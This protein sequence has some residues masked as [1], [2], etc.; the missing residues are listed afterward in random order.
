M[1]RSKPKSLAARFRDFDRRMQLEYR[2]INR[3][4]MTRELQRSIDEADRIIPMMN[5]K[6]QWSNREN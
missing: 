5:G 1:P 6:R 3:E 4:N 2:R